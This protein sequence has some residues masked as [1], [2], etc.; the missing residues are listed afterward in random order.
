MLVEGLC[1]LKMREIAGTWM[2][3]VKGLFKFFEFDLR[4]RMALMLRLVGGRLAFINPRRENLW[5][6]PSNKSHT[7]SENVLLLLKV[8]NPMLERCIELIS[9]NGV[10]LMKCFA[11]L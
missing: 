9:A 7:P 4:F 10:F 6:L 3:V 1:L 8:Y 2:C 5:G 11:L